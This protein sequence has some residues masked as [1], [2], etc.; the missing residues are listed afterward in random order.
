VEQLVARVRS[1]PG[2]VA[3]GIT[4]NLPADHLSWDTAYT[5]RGGTPFDPRN[6]PLTADRVVTPG[7]LETL[8]VELVS[9]R[10]LGESDRAG[11]E[12]VVVVTRD[13][14]E[15][16]WPGLDPLGKQVKRG[17]PDSDNPW[18][19]IVGVVEPVK[20]DRAAFRRDRP[21]WYVP[22]EQ[23]ETDRSP[24]LVVRAEGDAVALRS[25]IREAIREV[26]PALPVYEH[27]DLEAHLDELFANDR[28]G[29]ALLS[30]FSGLGL[31]L[32]AV[33]IYGVLASA[34]ESRRV[35][36]GLRVALGADTRRL[37][38]GF[39]AEGVALGGKG[40]ALGLL[41]SVGLGTTISSLLFRV[42][43]HDPAVLAGAC[44]VGLVVSLA[45]SYGPAR[46][47]TTVDA[48]RVIRG[49]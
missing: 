20:E 4:T 23:L 47:A 29:V 48:A 34:V 43:P 45:A 38:L 41:A 16:A 35:E 25:S 9:G 40:T 10:L 37:V 22:Y 1:I 12:P 21:A 27:V 11:A 14:A 17:L 36:I 24:S 3:A 2:V 33:G 7:Y 39:A 32:A 42:H 13:F 31:L 5:P 30:L 6:V 19:T 28:F 15:R 44:L 49:D 8:G 46:R 26:A 18:M